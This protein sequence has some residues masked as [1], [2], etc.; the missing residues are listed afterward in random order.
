ML[1]FTTVLFEIRITVLI[2][3]FEERGLLM[4]I[5]VM[6]SERDTVLGSMG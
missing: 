1:L 2:E 6:Q 3:R 5:D 4:M